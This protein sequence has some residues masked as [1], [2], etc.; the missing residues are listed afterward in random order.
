[1]KRW[2]TVAP[3]SGVLIV[4]RLHAQR[5]ESTWIVLLSCTATVEQKSS[6]AQAPARSGRSHQT[7]PPVTR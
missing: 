5:I 6:S 3:I 4:M 7:A 2:K 1:M